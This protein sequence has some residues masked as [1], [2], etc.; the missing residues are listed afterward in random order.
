MLKLA[1]WITTLAG[2]VG[3]ALLLSASKHVGIPL[4]L[5]TALFTA[6]SLIAAILLPLDFGREDRE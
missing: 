2:C 6:A 5:F 4:I 1:A 3:L